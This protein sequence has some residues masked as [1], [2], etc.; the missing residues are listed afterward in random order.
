MTTH[1]SSD[2]ESAEMNRVRKRLRQQQRNEDDMP[3]AESSDSSIVSQASKELGPHNVPSGAHI[4]SKPS[5]SSD[6]QQ[7]SSAIQLLAFENPQWQGQSAKKN[8]DDGKISSTNGYQKEL[9]SCILA[10]PAPCDSSNL[11][12]H[13][14]F[15]E[16]SEA[17]DELD[18]HV[19]ASLEAKSTMNQ[20]PQEVA[21]AADC[22]LRDC[23]LQTTTGEIQLLESNYDSSL[24]VDE[25]IPR[26]LDREVGITTK[27]SNKTLFK[28]PT[29]EQLKAQK[30]PQS[31]PF[32]SS[33]SD[34]SD[35]ETKNILLETS[36]FSVY[37]KTV[38]ACYD[39]CDSS[40][41]G[42]DVKKSQR[43][44]TKR[45]RTHQK[46]AISHNG[47]N[48][49]K[50]KELP[51]SRP[52]QQRQAERGHTLQSNIHSGPK[53]DPSSRGPLVGTTEEGDASSEDSFGFFN[54]D[55]INKIE[56]RVRS[57][58]MKRSSLVNGDTF[59]VSSFSKAETKQIEANFADQIVNQGSQSKAFDIAI[60]QPQDDIIDRT[61]HRDES[62]F[63][64]AFGFQEV[65]YIPEYFPSQT[66]QTS[67][68]VGSSE[69]T[70]LC[71]L[72][73]HLYHDQSS[74][75]S[76][77]T[78]ER[79]SEI[80]PKL[81]AP[82]L[83]KKIH[84]PIVHRFSLV[85]RPL[86]SRRRVPVEQ[87]FPQPVGL[88]WRTNFSAFNQMQSELANV[89]AYSDDNIVVS[90]PTGAGKTALFEMAMARFFTLNLQRQI[91][92]L[93]ERHHV[94]KSQKIVYVS[95]SKALC[96]ERYVDWTT[97]LGSMNLGIQVALIT[98]DGDPS[99]SYKDLA[100][101]NVVLTT[102]EKWDSL[103]RRWTENFF[104]F[105]SVKLFLVDEVHLVADDSRGWCLETIICR[106]KTIQIAAQRISVT[107]I[108]LQHSSYNNTTPE[109]IN[110]SMR[111]VA[112]SATLPNLEDIATF[113]E[114]NEAHSFDESYRPVPLTV[115]VISQGYV[116]DSSGN[117][118]RFWS[119]LD[120]NI[121]D[122]IH[123]FSQKKPSLVFCHSKADTEKLTELLAVERG[124]GCRSDMNSHLAGQTKDTRLQRALFYG[125]AYHHAGLE[126]EDRHLVE[127]CFAEGKI[128]VLCA[129][130]TLAM[131]V[132]LPAHLVIIKG[133]KAWRGG[134]RG[135]CD[136]DQATLLQMIGRA[137]RPGFDS[138]GTAIIMTDNRSK[139]KFERLASQGL[140]PAVSKLCTKMDEIVNAEVS[141]NVIS[142]TESAFNW[143]TTTLFCA[144]LLRQPTLFG[145]A[146]NSAENSDEYLWRIC[147]D[148]LQRLEAIGALSSAGGKRV[149][150]LPA[151]H[152]M[153]HNLV[154]Y[155]AME[156]FVG[157]P[158]DAS[159]CAVLLSLSQIK[160]MHRP[161]RRSEKKT[162][163]LMHGQLKYK[164][165]GPLSK[166]T[167]QQPFEKAFV[168]LQ[169]SMMR[170][171]IEDHT[172]RQEM[173]MIVEF[174]SRML[175]ALEEFSVRSSRNGIVAL[176]SIR[177][178]RALSTND[179]VPHEGVLHQLAGVDSATAMN[180]KMAGI[181]SFDDV[182]KHSSE[183]IEKAAGRASHF[184]NR[185]KNTVQE[186]MRGMLTMNV[187][188]EDNIPGAALKTAVCVIGRLAK[189]TNHG[190]VKSSSK[191]LSY[192]LIAYC[193][194]SGKCILYRR[195][196]SSP[197][198]CR[199]RTS[200]DSQKVIFHLIAPAAGL[201]GKFRNR[202]IYRRR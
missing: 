63:N 57:E 161:V 130:S 17:L 146:D 95:P 65:P 8:I 33:D 123:R 9:S 120:R 76:I 5:P 194:R 159:Q 90:A 34:P 18:R 39:D 69:N 129:T 175:T 170:L 142:G 61:V 6:D 12:D 101:A 21:G 191:E 154:D 88:L 160:G 26:G 165:E 52:K 31:E 96:D 82:T 119:G 84:P 186:V 81:Y 62:N 87:V 137:G 28:Q 111:T 125:L 48:E 53:T 103:T 150:A 106:M 86:A 114:A 188:F 117:Q 104:L 162:L 44:A 72:E 51:R 169:A 131:G 91:R 24:L 38:R 20:V 155:R 184:G 11:G 148:S 156:Q 198:T 112:V 29:V 64:H 126:A 99:A 166:V 30:K 113:V 168:L 22:R 75:D 68:D 94:D 132:N 25:E 180:L 15:L 196:V 109:A 192:T 135:Y 1:T 144:Q 70:I 16:D 54:E 197:M 133:T 19:E 42:T 157:M 46:K 115:H 189:T 13:L 199:A 151:S 172:L 138:S 187:Y 85:N 71:S 49:K 171:P 100:N 177:L 128:R 50:L 174:S 67:D 134:G 110:A 102:P 105:A 4:R 116:G 27:P 79:I 201:D 14:S 98:G 183:Q 124:I 178:R 45:K 83:P 47:T 139:D 179:W 145:Q 141:Q 153:S 127:K 193:D 173:N 200:V 23:P 195:N 202:N 140:D 149:L 32:H 107:Q 167:I 37:T 118:F 97:R 7:T 122:L 158:K 136:L 185:L 147:I 181:C 143:I 190:E 41:P 35:R 3:V 182:L 108:E 80:D 74:F 2:D 89:V 58:Q 164:L 152:V 92:K 36:R 60:S 163:K 78:D 56:E 43:V 40:D 66:S 55:E 77:E 176:Q 73:R 59:H 121:P 10:D 93:D